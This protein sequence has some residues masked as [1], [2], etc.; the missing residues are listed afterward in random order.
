L[1]QKIWRETRLVL[2]TKRTSIVSI[3]PGFE[4]AKKFPR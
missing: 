1:K 3:Y 4:R 2:A